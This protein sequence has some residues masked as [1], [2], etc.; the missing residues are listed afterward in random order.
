MHN[1]SFICAREEDSCPY[2]IP[3]NRCLARIRTNFTVKKH[4]CWFSCSSY[5]NCIPIYFYSQL[6]S[7]LLPGKIIPL[8][9]SSLANHVYFENKWKKLFLKYL[10]SKYFKLINTHWCDITLPNW[11]VKYPSIANQKYKIYD[12]QI[13]FCG[14]LPKKDWIISVKA[15]FQ[16]QQLKS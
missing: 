3:P 15:Y 7:A 12:C 10:I 2:N 9:E 11:K 1:Q 16:P 5:W 8:T 6:V 14:S 13:L 4:K